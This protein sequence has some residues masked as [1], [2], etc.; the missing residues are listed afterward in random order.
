LIGL[1]EELTWEAT[2]FG[3]RLRLTSRIT[4][5]RRPF[6]FRDSQVRGAF[7]RFDHDLFSE[8]D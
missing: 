4:A 7:R 3:I 5:Y 1:D 8:V 6:H 2:H